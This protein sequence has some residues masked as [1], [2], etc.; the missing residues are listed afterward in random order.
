MP[1]GDQQYY[2]WLF[3]H[4]AKQRRRNLLLGLCLEAADP[5]ELNN[6][7]P[8]YQ[9]DSVNRWTSQ[10]NDGATSAEILAPETPISGSPSPPANLT[11]EFL[12]FRV[13]STLMYYLRY[14][15]SCRT[16]PMPESSMDRRSFLKSAIT[17]HHSGKSS[18]PVGVPLGE[19][20]LEGSPRV[21]I[22]KRG[23]R[24]LPRQ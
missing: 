4:R 7:R 5:L 9:R 6:G 23:H 1:R 10:L 24:L 3:R 13:V 20:N 2:S 18:R 11:N 17:F 12:H 8:S 15:A 14:R 22:Q 16:F 21:K 19:L